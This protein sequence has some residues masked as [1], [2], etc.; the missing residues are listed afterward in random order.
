MVDVILAG[1]E[2]RHGK[3]TRHYKVAGR[4]MRARLIR[5]PVTIETGEEGWYVMYS[6]TGIP[7][8]WSSADSSVDGLEDGERYVRHVFAEIVEAA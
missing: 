5:Y 2:E 1:V 3:V 4:D 6:G 7:R 8:A